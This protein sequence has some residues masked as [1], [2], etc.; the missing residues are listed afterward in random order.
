MFGQLFG[1]C[2]FGVSC[3][4]ILQVLEVGL[5]GYVIFNC[6]NEGL[7]CFS[8]LLGGV[9]FGQNIQWLNK[10]LEYFGKV[11]GVGGLILILVVWRGVIESQF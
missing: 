1:I 6:V 4:L 7:I 9:Y 10:Y 11:V 5:G 8:L 2:K 3:S